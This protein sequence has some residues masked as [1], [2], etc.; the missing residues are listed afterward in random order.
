MPTP[1]SFL[2]LLGFGL[3]LGLLVRY[4]DAIRTLGT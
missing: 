2:A 4:A 1:N 3:D